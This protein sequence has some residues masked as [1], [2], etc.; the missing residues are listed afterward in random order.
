[1]EKATILYEGKAKKVYKTNNDNELRLEYLDQATALNGKKKEQV[2]GK[3]A[4]NNQITSRIFDYLT[5]KKIRHHW[6]KQLSETEQLVQAV[7]IIPLE[8]VVRNVATGSFTRRL[9]VEEGVGLTPPLIEFY[10]KE[11]TLDD[12]LVTEEHIRFLKLATDDEIQVIK[13]EAL[14]INQV[15]QL[16]FKEMDLKLIDFKLEFGKNKAGTILLADEVT[17]DTCR[18]WDSATNAS[19]DKDLFRKDLGDIIPVYQEILQRL[20]NRVKKEDKKMYQVNVYVSY[21]DS[22]LDPQAEVITE[23][24][25]HLE[26]GTIKNLKI[27]KQFDFSIDA[28]DLATA[29]KQVDQ[30]CD[31]LLANVTMESYEFSVVEVN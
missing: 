24:M 21:K 10:F 6:L 13:K 4:L 14:K 16:L 30:L 1:M 2:V 8:V 22:V 7:E 28:T 11:D 20:E 25:N 23:A 3:G 27:G 29:E 19:Y 12:P 31:Q 26:K 18:L 15:L 5:R 9:G 17:P